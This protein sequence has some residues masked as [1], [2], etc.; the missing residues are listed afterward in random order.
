MRLVHWALVVLIPFAWWSATHDHLAWHL[1]CGLTIL[2]LLVFRLIWGVIGSPAARFARFLAGPRTVSAYVRGR[3]DRA[4]AGHNPLGGWSVVA[5]LAALC[6]QVGLGLFSINEDGDEGGPLSGRV[7][8]EAARA[9]THLHHRLFWV[10]VALAG[11]HIA[12][13][14]FYAIRRQNLV[15]AMIS[16]RGT[17]PAGTQPEPPMK[18]WRAVAGAVVAAVVAVLIARNLRL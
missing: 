18:L 6:L 10:V 7:S 16:G 2:G 14:G 17:L 4:V 3:L 9:A 12:A 13:I 15:A 11:L 8:F 5:M 1:V